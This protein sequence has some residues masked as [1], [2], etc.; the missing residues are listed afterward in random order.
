MSGE[1]KGRR[2]DQRLV[3]GAGRYTGDWNLPRQ[4]YAMFRRADRAHAK[5]RAIDTSAAKSA[6]GV[7]AVF[8][9]KDVADAGFKTLPPLAHFPG[10]GGMHCIVPERPVLARDRVRFAGEEVAVVI[11][12]TRA[13]ATDAADLVEIDYEDLPSVIGFD[14]ALAQGTALLHDTIPGNVCFDFEYGNEAKATEAIKSAP[15]KSQRHHRKPARRAQHDGDA[16]R[17]GV[18]RRRFGQV[19]DLVRP[20]GRP[21]DARRTRG[22]DGR[23]LG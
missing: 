5:I 21:S 22:D 19:R 13:Q 14:T 20:P 4:L 23:A 15:P 3:T 8:T 1:F 10:R 16:R 7:V 9:G 12:E 11:A 18:L 17:A 2:E 6:P